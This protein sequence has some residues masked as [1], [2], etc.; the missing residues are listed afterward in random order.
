MDSNTSTRVES[1]R[2]PTPKLSAPQQSLMLYDNI[3]AHGPLTQLPDYVCH[4][5]ESFRFSITFRDAM[6][7]YLSPFCPSMS[8]GN[9]ANGPNG[10]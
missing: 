1:I 10:N 3:Q 8:S 7:Y 2:I 5:R 9:P 6:P 4:A